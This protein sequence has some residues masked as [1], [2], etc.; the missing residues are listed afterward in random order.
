MGWGRGACCCTGVAGIAVGPGV[1]LLHLQHLAFV[2]IAG[3]K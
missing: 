1:S 3:K 2:L